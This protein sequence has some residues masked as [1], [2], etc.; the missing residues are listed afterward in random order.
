E[1]ENQLLA[2]PKKE[3]IDRII[4]KAFAICG[5]LFSTN[6]QDIS[7]YNF[8]IMTSEHKEFL[9]AFHDLSYVSHMANL[10]FDEIEKILIKIE[11]NK[12][13]GIISDNAS[14]IAAMHRQINQKYPSIMNLH[15]I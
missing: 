9:Y 7:I 14:A 15:C 1:N 8:L 5:L 10:L 4:I 3:A 6:P 11:P 12:F 13:V 2:R